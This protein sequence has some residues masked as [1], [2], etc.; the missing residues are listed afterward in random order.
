MNNTWEH[1]FQKGG[2]TE[3]TQSFE[4]FQIWLDMGNK[5]S[6][7]AVAEKVEKSHDTIKKYSCTWKWSERLQDKLSYENQQIHSMQLEPI[8]TSLEVDSAQDIFVQEIMSNILYVLLQ[9]TTMTLNY[10]QINDKGR[11]DVSYKV[12][13]MERLTNMYSKLNRIHT[14]NQ[15]KLV[16]LNKQC[17]RD[18]EFENKKQYLE[19]IRN[20]KKQ[21]MTIRQSLGEAYT[22]LSNIDEEHNRDQRNYAGESMRVTAP[23][24]S[25]KTQLKKLNGEQQQLNKPEVDQ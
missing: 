9:E 6:L 13:L 18:I 23:F 5:R 11:L 21:Q 2:K 12:E 4:A 15:N 24:K 10:S 25:Y 1:P 8:L 3:P 16:N 20:G 22:K 7:K 14:D 19:L 17:L